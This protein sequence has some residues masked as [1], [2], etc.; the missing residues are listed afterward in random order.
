MK[1]IKKVALLHSLCG[2]GK[3]SL[4]NMLPIFST[5]G[6]EAC[7]IPTVLLS[8]H[9][10]GYGSPA[11]QTV[12]AEY[13][14]ACAKHYRQNSVQF[15]AIFIGYL[16]SVE[17]VSAVRYFVEQF[18]KAVVLLDPIMGDHGTFYSQLD[19]NYV[20]A[21][22]KL[23]PYINVILP[24]VT[25]AG[26]L[27]G[28]PYKEFFTQK[29]FKGMCEIMHEQGIQ[30]VVITSACTE[31]LTKGIVI[32]SGEKMELMEI[33]TED[34]EFHGTGDAFAAVTIC[35]YLQ[36]YTWKESVK[37]AHQF[38]REC[39]QETMRRDYDKREGLLLET[40]LSLLV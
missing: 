19:A 11:R 27:T 17:M 34:A 1:P 28:T 5:M 33:D 20:E 23:C 35:S 26:F 37:R 24:N 31:S 7:P 3:A 18:P 29:E 12:N 15:D 8:T 32:S 21:F 40:K 6:V 38:V 4:T 39:I 14:R 16:G 2:V 36:G 25:E 9:T 22:K 30:T 13:I 10:G